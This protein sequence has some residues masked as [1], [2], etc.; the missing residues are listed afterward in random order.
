MGNIRIDI[1]TKSSWEDVKRIYESGIASK[2]ATFEVAS[3]D[4]EKWDQ[5]HLQA[6]RMVAVA[7]NKIAGWAALMKISDRRVFEGVAEESIYIDPAFQGRGIGDILLKA[8]IRESEI[9]G[10]WS[11][12]AGIFPEN[13]ISIRLHLNNGFRIL[14]TR[15]RMGKMDNIWRDVTMLERRS[16]LVGID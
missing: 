2:N 7:E 6:C 12:Q 1:L 10:I 3:P 5:S 13:Q 15:E 11:L 16:N 9:Q 8:L 4:W 14:G